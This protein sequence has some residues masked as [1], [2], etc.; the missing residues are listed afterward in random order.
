MK[1]SSPMTESPTEKWSEP[2][3]PCDNLLFRSSLTATYD[4][5]ARAQAEDGDKK[6]HCRQ[7]NHARGIH[8]GRIDFVD[9]LLLGLNS[10]TARFL[11]EPTEHAGKQV[12]I[13]PRMVFAHQSIAG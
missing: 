7:Q 4:P 8:L 5:D 11:T 6:D 10:N 1:E 2:F 3:P 9:A 13:A 12:E